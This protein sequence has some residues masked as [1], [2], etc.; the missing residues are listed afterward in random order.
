MAQLTLSRFKGETAVNFV[1]R[2]IASFLGGVSGLV[3][4]YVST[5]SGKG[6]PYGL[7]AA[8]A[9]FFPVSSAHEIL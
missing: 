1:C 6:N 7:A 3:L 2:I 8:A 5:G 9:I 4:W